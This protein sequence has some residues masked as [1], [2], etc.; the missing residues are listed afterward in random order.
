MSNK[1]IY[2]L[3]LFE[4]HADIGSGRFGSGH[5]AR[6]RLNHRWNKEAR[7]TC[8]ATTTTSHEAKTNVSAQPST[9]AADHTCAQSSG[10]S[11]DA[12]SLS[13]SNLDMKHGNGAAAAQTI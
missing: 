11:N 9:T 6:A 8:I 12:L 13:Q 1:D 5:P 7:S 2:E 4:L 3:S 10:M